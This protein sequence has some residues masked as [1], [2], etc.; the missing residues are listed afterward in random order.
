MNKIKIASRL[1]S[2]RIEV[3]PRTFY[4]SGLF[5]TTQGCS[6]GGGGVKGQQSAHLD[7]KKIAKTQEKEGENKENMGKSGRFF[8]FA[9]P[10]R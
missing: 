1:L 8:H 5:L 4:E 3:D 2:A 9:S 6:H 7:S 10:D